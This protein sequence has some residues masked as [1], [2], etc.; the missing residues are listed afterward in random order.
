MKNKNTILFKTI[1]IFL[2]SI[3]LLANVSLANAMGNTKENTTEESKSYGRLNLLTGEMSTEVRTRNSLN[4]RTYSKGVTDSLLL[5]GPENQIE[6]YSI[7]IGN[8][9]RKPIP[10]Q[11]RNLQDH[12]EK[13][14][15]IFQMVTG[16]LGLAQ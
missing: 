10:N 6:P 9:N 11:W 7:I 12:S 15:H 5:Q 13:W 16:V 8:N 2:S 3:I 4:S 1:A 14:F